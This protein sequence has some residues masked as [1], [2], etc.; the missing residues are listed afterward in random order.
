MV[1]SINADNQSSLVSLAEREV[2]L[3]SQSGFADLSVNDTAKLV[4]LMKEIHFE[5]GEKIVC[6][7]ELIDSVYIIVSGTCEVT[8]EVTVNNKS[9][10]SLLSTLHNGDAIGLKGGQFFSD[11]G[12]RAATV[13]ATTPCLLLKI[14]LTDLKNFLD[15]RPELLETL[16]AK[17]TWMLRMQLIRQAAPFL[18]LNPSQLA[19][20]ASNVKEI[21]V[22]PNQIIFQQGDISDA[23]YLLCEGK[24]EISGK[25]EE[26]NKHIF[27][28]LEP[29]SLLG[30]VDNFKFA[31]R[32]A[33]ARA[34][35]TG[36]LLVI[37]KEVLS[38]LAS[39]EEDNSEKETT[40]IQRHTRPRRLDNIIYQHR[41]TSDGQD[42]TVI[43]NPANDKYLQL[44]QEGW[45]LWT[46]MDGNHTVA[47][48]SLLF[49]EK[50]GKSNT[51]EVK[52]IVQRLIESNF[53]SIDSDNSVES[54]RGEKK[55]TSIGS[56]INFTYFLKKPDKKIGF[57][58]NHFGF[59]FFNIPSCIIQ[60]ALIISG[61]IL[62][63]NN[64][65][66]V[67][68]HLKSF[69]NLPF[70][71]V[72]VIIVSMT[73]QL[74]S[75]LIKAFAIK[76]FNYEIP[77]FGIIWKKIGPIGIVDTSDMWLSSSRTQAAV[78]L[79]GILANIVIASLFSFYAWYLKDLDSSVFFWLCALF[80]YLQTLHSLNPLLDLE[81][82]EL[83]YSILNRPQLR[84]TSI[85]WLFRKNSSSKPHKQ[86]CIFWLYSLGYLFLSV[87]FT[88]LIVE[89]LLVHQSI[90]AHFRS[91]IITSVIVGLISLFFVEILLTAK[92]QSEDKESVN[93]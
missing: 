58:Y 3:R 79:A 29:Y 74:I 14:I 54:E 86:E 93:F 37:D 50:F 46:Q 71:F 38:E 23:C 17:N 11:T 33:T 36:T 27:T 15:N 59:I 77:Q 7:G 6:E 48:L 52:S 83:L 25:K 60:I 85:R 62:F 91:L 18:K 63:Y 34:L 44:S 10:V 45:F 73:C 2:L 80:I 49:S 82:Y 20:L 57:L 87:C 75:T 70:L 90:Y 88:M 89:E 5:S 43:K 24:I 65:A 4:G 40:L 78:S 55:R 32:N 84:K 13:T 61:F 92:A 1:H 51:G 81:G 35:T 56:L 21:T 53:A 47:E 66:P 67:V 26:G 64:I 42:F 19:G 68:D 72:K 8:H 31:K 39:N 9:W 22:S 41:T 69:L 76:H 28:V 12:V 30:E 16:Q